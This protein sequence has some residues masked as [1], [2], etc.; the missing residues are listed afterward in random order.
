MALRFRDERGRFGKVTDSLDVEYSGAWQQDVNEIV[1]DV[2]EDRS[3]DDLCESSN[4]LSYLVV[5]L[6][7]NAPIVEVSREES[8]LGSSQGC[9]QFDRR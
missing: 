6:P 9:W 7:E 3:D 1:S 2:R 8:L 5:A 4:P